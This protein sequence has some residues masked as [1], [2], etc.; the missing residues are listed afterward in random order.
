MEKKFK[1]GFLGRAL[2]FLVIISLFA[3]S[4]AAEAP[5]SL[6][7]HQFYGEVS[8]DKGSAVPVQV[9][10]KIAG[11]TY[12][13]EVMSLPCLV[14]PCIGRYGY[15]AS[16]ILRVQGQDGE[17]ISFFVGSIKVKEYTYKDGEATKLDLDIRAAS[18]QAAAEAQ[19]QA[20][21]EVQE[22]DADSDE[23]SPAETSQNESLPAVP[24]QAE[25]SPLLETSVE[26]IPL[27][28]LPAEMK[29]FDFDAPAPQEQKQ[30]SAAKA[31]KKGFDF[32]SV[33][34]IPS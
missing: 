6:S 7:N 28:E 27:E 18:L 1:I 4:I 21:A 34:L 3:A 29:I 24:L 9:N 13:S 2:I 5:P 31:E 33:P 30:A 26:Q 22:E 16:N 15:E 14:N 25:Q 12:V 11:R 17:V 20:A 10:A 32:F 8:W 19:A 23:E